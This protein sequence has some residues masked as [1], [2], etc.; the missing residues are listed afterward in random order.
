MTT[1]SPRSPL[2]LGT[3]GSDLALWQAR[4]VA[5][6]LADRGVTSEIVVIKTRGD[7]RTDVPFADL[8]GQGFFT[9][10]LEEA[11]R[12][13]R[14]D[15]AV[16]SLKD[17]AAD[18][19][20]GLVLAAL[21]GRADARELLL[22]RPGAVDPKRREAG[23]PLPL[24]S[25]ARVGTSAVR[26][27]AQL[28]IRRPDVETADLRGNVPTRVRKLREGKY[29]AILVAAAGVARLNLDLSGLAAFPVAPEVIVP[30]PGQGM[31]A[32]QCRDEAPL[33]SLLRPLHAGSDAAAAEVERRLLAELGAGCQ[34]PLGVHVRAQDTGWRLDLFWREPDGGPHLWHAARGGDP[35]RLATVALAEIR[36]L[37]QR[38]DGSDPPRERALP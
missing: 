34:M 6:L 37:R 8:E 10:E 25:G 12:D 13:G 31:L 3:R 11:L 14:I 35:H 9:R 24:R 16:H 7:R 4:H 32:V 22:A 30:A 28:R 5:G 27:R 20:A 33:R 19:P 36:A 38:R 18:Q 26:R 23:D 1:S 29:D 15:L 21:V 17:L 2:R